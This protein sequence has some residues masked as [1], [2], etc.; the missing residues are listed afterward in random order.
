MAR[1]IVNTTTQ[2]ENG[3]RVATA[4]RK[5][6]EALSEIEYQNDIIGECADATEVEATYGLEAGQGAAFTALLAA[7]D[8]A[9]SL[10]AVYN[11]V[12]RVG[13]S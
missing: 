12:S 7:L 3:D 11:L 4:A 2:T 6:K 9:S 5:L 10:P 13:R 1:I 8:G